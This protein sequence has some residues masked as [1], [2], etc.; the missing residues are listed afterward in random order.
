MR[1]RQICWEDESC[2]TAAILATGAEGARSRLLQALPGLAH[3]RHGLREHG[4]HDAAD[5]LRLLGR[6]ALDVDAV[7]GR[8]RHLHCEADRV[9]GPGQL[10]LALHLLREL[11][12][13]ALE[14]VW[15]AEESTKAFHAPTVARSHGATHPGPVAFAL[16][17][18]VLA[19]GRDDLLERA[20][21][22]DEDQ[23]GEPDR[24]A[25]G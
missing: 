21:L 11:R 9:V 1:P 19:P 15:V 14:L 20:E 25:E 8:D 13:A 12:H 16:G 17:L 7:D 24:Q 22:E 5:L 4:R 6:R 18:A 2:A 3:Q 10:L 23:R